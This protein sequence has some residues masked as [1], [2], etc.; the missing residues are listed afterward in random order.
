MILIL[1]IRSVSQYYAVPFGI[2]LARMMLENAGCVVLEA[3]NG[4]VALKQVGEYRPALI[5]RDLTMVE[6]DGF[7]FA[8]ELGRHE[9]WRS[10]AVVGLTAKDLN[11]G[12]LPSLYGNVYSLIDKGESYR[13]ELMHQV[14]DLIAGWAVPAKRNGH[15]D[16]VRVDEHTKAASHV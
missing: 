5:L 8:A 7:A 4:R 6:S 11:A 16:H 9:A 3:E 15:P 10:I 13:D 14:S 12:Q 2:L 1:T